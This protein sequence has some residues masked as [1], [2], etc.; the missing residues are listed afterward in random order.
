VFIPPVTLNS[1]FLPKRS[2][3]VALLAFSPKAWMRSF[4]D[5]LNASLTSAVYLNTNRGNLMQLKVYCS[6]FAM[7][8]ASLVGRT[9]PARGK[10][11]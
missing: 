7:F 8:I 5:W 9:R 6:A 11:G 3:E 10:K 4:L 1:T 2:E